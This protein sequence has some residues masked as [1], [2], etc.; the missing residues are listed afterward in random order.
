VAHPARAARRLPGEQGPG[1]RGIGPVT[2]DQHHRGGRVGALGPQQ[3]RARDERRGVRDAEAAQ[4]LR[5]LRHQVA[6][7]PAPGRRRQRREHHD[8]QRPPG[9]EGQAEHEPGGRVAERQRDARQRGHGEREHER[10]EAEA[11]QQTVAGGGDGQRD[12]PPPVLGHLAA[13][14]GHDPRAARLQRGGHEDR[15]RGRPDGDLS[16]AQDRAE[17]RQRPE[18]ERPAHQRARDEGRAG[19][20]GRAPSARVAGGSERGHHRQPAR[21]PRAGH[22]GGEGRD[23]QNDQHGTRVS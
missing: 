13:D 6:G 5:A 20:D 14:L 18:R 3:Q 7:A 23:G 4:D 16:A 19:R 21:R 22:P 1:Q 9:A 12:H 11:E 15:P 17:Q 10:R 2:R 8:R